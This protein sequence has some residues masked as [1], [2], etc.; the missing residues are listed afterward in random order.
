M[1]VW[2][3]GKVCWT[4]QSADQKTNADNVEEKHDRQSQFSSGFQSGD[5]SELE[6]VP[7]V[8]PLKEFVLELVLNKNIEEIE[9]DLP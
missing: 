2:I 3:R 9:L 6:N 4:D 8:S 1:L 7:F 5:F